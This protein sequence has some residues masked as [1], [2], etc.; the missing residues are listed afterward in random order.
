[1]TD[2]A[3]KR[4]L[5]RD[6]KERKQPRGVFAVTCTATGERW[7]A[8]SQNLDK[9]QNSLWFTLKLGSHTN[10]ALQTAWKTHGEEAFSYEI[11][12]TLDDDPAA[13]AQTIRADLK[14]MEELWR[15]KFGAKTVSG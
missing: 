3:R 14:A 9:Q 15:E 1:M 2:N 6:Y 11:L 4:D 12:D 13:D 7:I 8:A 5:V 10:R